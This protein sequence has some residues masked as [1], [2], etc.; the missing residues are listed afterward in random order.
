MG[1][2]IACGGGDAIY[3]QP[4][5]SVCVCVCVFVWA[6]NILLFTLYADGTCIQCVGTKYYTD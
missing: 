2:E 1:E 5:E 4:P 3:Q 6:D